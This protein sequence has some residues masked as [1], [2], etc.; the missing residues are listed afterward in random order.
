MSVSVAQA[1]ISHARN[2]M[3]KLK[4]RRPTGS[5]GAICE[6]AAAI[7]SMQRLARVFKCSQFPS[8]GR[9]KSHSGHVQKD[10]E[11]E[12]V[13]NSEQAIADFLQASIDFEES[14]N[15]ATRQIET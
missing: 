14:Q 8:E 5:N 11:E 15:R 2:S 4:S 1:N 3:E 12:R 9:E 6:L 7:R 10:G 13:I